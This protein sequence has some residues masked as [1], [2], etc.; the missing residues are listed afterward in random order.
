MPGGMPTLRESRPSGGSPSL[1][2]AVTVRWRISSGEIWKPYMVE[3]RNLVTG[4]N[5]ASAAILAKRLLEVLDER[6]SKA[7]S[8][9][10]FGQRPDTRR[11]AAHQ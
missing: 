1:S 3:D 5:P 10:P 4:Q 2:R 7:P 6:A 11:A 9:R 8:G